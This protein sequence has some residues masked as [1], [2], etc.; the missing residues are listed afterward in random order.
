VSINSVQLYDLRRDPGEWYDLA[1]FYPEKVKELEEL[2]KK[3]RE[4]LGDDITNNP[5]E[6]RRKAGSID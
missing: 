4:D 1:A 2:A 6:N 3:A 5:G